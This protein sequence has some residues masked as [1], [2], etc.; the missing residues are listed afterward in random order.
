MRVLSYSFFVL[1]LLLGLAKSAGSQNFLAVKTEP[2]A[3]DPKCVYVTVKSL[4][5]ASAVTVTS[6]EVRVFYQDGCNSPCHY[7]HSFNLQIGPCK[8]TTQQRVCCSPVAE[9][10]R[11]YR[12]KVWATVTPTTGTPFSIVGRDWLFV[13]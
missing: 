13:P 3:G 10:P 5:A 8:E 1:I 4:Y 7:K 12:V 9:V 2:V 11:I 6:I